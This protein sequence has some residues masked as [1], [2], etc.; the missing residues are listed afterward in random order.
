MILNN[1][2]TN[3][4]TALREKLNLSQQEFAD[5]IGITQGALSQLES[6]KSTLSLSTITK[7]SQVFNVDCNWLI[8]GIEGYDDSHFQSYQKVLL[9][10]T[11]PSL[12]L[13]HDK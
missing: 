13:S 10:T 8:L 2:S 4:V 12:F 11:L 1:T 9:C 6:G 3:R 7:I 5:K